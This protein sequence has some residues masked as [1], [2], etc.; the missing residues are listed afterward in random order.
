M[1]VFMCA[2]LRAAVEWWRHSEETVSH[3]HEPDDS[4]LAAG[5]GTNVPRQ[6]AARACARERES[7]ADQPLPASKHDRF[8][9]GVDVELAEDTGHVVAHGLLADEDARGDFGVTQTQGEMSKYVE[10]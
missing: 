4:F 8:R 9:P 5:S 3:R 10:L 7:L 6:R 2:L 1:Q